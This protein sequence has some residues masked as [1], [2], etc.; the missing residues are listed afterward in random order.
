M[1]RKLLVVVCSCA[2][3]FYAAGLHAQL[4][5][6]PVPAIPLP[7]Q[8]IQKPVTRISPSLQRLYET[9]A[10]K[11]TQAPAD[12]PWM[13]NDALDKYLQVKDGRVVVD[14]T[15]KEH[16]PAAS[17]ALQQL[18][19]KIT[20]VYGRVI[21]GSIPVA[22][23]PKLQGVSA[24]QY[25]KPAYRPMRRLTGS[26]AHIQYRYSSLLG[27]AVPVPV[28]SQGDTAQRSYLARKKYNT[29]GKGVKV[30]ILSDSYNNLGTAAIGIQKGEL[31]GPGN[32]FNYKKPVEVLEDLTDS[33]GTDEGRA[34]A[35]IVH[36]V[37][38]GAQLAFHTAFL[39]A[40]DFA[41]GIQ[42]LVNKGCGV[43]ADDI[44]Y[45]DEPF[46]QD[47][48]IAQSIDLAKKKGVA[49]FSAAGNN[50]NN[51]YES[52][53]HPTKDEVMG[54]GNGTAHNFSAAGDFPRYYQP[55]YIPS[56][57][58][59]I[60]SFQWDQ[61]SFSAGG[62]ANESDLDIY[63]IDMYG[64]I[65]AAGATDNIASGDP[66]ELFGY[67]NHTPNYTFF[68]VIVKYAGIDPTHLKYNLYKDGQFYITTPAIP[69][70]FAPT[71]VGH[72]KAEGAITTGA[73]FYRSSPAYGVDTPR[74][75]WYSSLAG[76][77]NY[78]DVAGKRI[79]P[80]IR[81]KPDI[82]APDGGNTSFFNPFGN[83]DIVQDADSFP[84][85]FGTSAAAPHA[86]GVAALMLEAERLK[87][88]TPGQLKGIL[89]AHTTDMDNIYTP[90]FDK[91]F[92]LNTGY[93]LI[94]A[95]EAVAA[96]A[97]PHL[98]IK[99][100]DLKAVCSVN[101]AASRSWKIINPNPFDVQTNWLLLGT[102]QHG[103][104]TAPPG[105]SVFSTATFNLGYY[106]VPNIVILDWD[107]N[108]SFTRLDIAY[109]SSV[110][111]GSSSARSLPGD[112]S[113]DAA[114]KPMLA[115]VYPNPSAGIF[116]VY[117]ALA[118]QQPVY[119]Q[120][121]SIDGKKLQEKRIS[122]GKGIVPIDAA[123]YKPGIYLLQVTQG[124]FNKTIKLVKQ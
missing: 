47:G 40:A 73:A 38:P 110:A 16:L 114:G 67:D 66:I 103:S 118:D 20:G 13:A 90:G 78:F 65:V 116:K 24:I 52:D 91:G 2:G 7:Q 101:P 124:T 62:A 94:Q 86:A 23:L 29:T 119:L 35:E 70:L 54:P 79:A 25:A 84:N 107:D 113:E 12:K 46:F 106:R 41:Q 120:L 6:D 57:G 76:V 69:G 93:G 28:V 50:L 75:E 109:S 102:N 42:D 22:A 80:L 51:S 85:F 96:V 26:A 88:L 5:G 8:A 98:Y 53:Y 43:I 63:L 72:A 30:G 71:L 59:F 87:N 10:G 121:F 15:V 3:I 55:V 92:D 74:V 48:I 49:F 19:L 11:K 31:P 61:P 122:Q 45:F 33:S 17:I 44:A 14:I 36:D 68:L 112:T 108:F 1:K 58:S 115:D 77:A 111:C 27:G 81:R 21:S 100:L 117:L 56:G 82:T 89:S 18:G 64:N 32:P 99:N 60:A 123:T 9:A 39:G 34:M 104:I 105:E 37:A 97:F 4:K 83:G 95:D